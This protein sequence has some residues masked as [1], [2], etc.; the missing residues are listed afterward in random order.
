[1]NR[2]ALTLAAAIT[3]S[4]LSTTALAQGKVG[5]IN[6]TKVF[7]EFWR[8]K[9]A[10]IQI[11]D[12][13]SEFEKMGQSMYDD[14]KKANEEFGKQIE[15]ANDPALSK[16]E[17]EK[18]RKDLDKKR[19]DIMEMENNIKQFQGNSQRALM[20]QRGRVR[21]SILR[22]VRG[23]IE[24]KSKAGGYNT[25]LDISAQSAN[26]TPVVIF[27]TLAGGESDLSDSVAK[28]LAATAPPDSAKTDA[29]KTEAKDPKKADENKAE[30]K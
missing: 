4:L 5:V 22:D 20:E 14:Y 28:A 9:Q 21:E 23:V 27:T 18:R 17:S 13:L 8:T 6:L 3:A 7:D 11:K 26:G 10:D 2:T 16:E 30:K 24:E 19:K 15:A 1:M 12:R 29:P 25:V